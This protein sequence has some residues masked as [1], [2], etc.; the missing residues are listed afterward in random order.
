MKVLITAGPTWIKIDDIRIITTIFTGG[1]GLYLAKE[2]KKNGDDVT[3]LI[4]S[5]Y[6]GKI[7]DLNVI[8]F[9]YFD[10]F[11]KIVIE[12]LK[13][14]NYDLIIHSAAVSDYRLKRTFSGKIPSNKNLKLELV[15]TEKIIKIIK[16][17]A[18][19]SVVVQFK[20]EI[21]RKD[22]IKK[23]YNSLLENKSNFVVANA[24]DDLKKDYKAFII[25]REKNIIE[26][27]SKK[28]LFLNLNK[29]FKSKLYDF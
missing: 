18:K 23:A 21:K 11:K 26:V 5:H 28:E 3:L 19:D 13:K 10:E 27:N 14:N 8:N 7:K 25:D 24:L 12:T 16:R 20:L 6:I 17:L 1:T 29:L 9:R 15:P 22:L 4:N 2:F